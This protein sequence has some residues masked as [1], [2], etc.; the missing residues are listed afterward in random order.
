VLAPVL[1]GRPEPA[2]MSPFTDAAVLTP[3]YGNPPTVVCGPG[4]SD[5]AHRTDEWCSIARIEQAV[6]A[7][8]EI[9][10][11]WCGL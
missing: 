1:G 7:Y 11:R 9:A 2:G 4:E 5:Q 3:A 10:R 8:A 6:D